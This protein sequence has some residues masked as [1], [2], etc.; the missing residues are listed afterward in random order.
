LRPAPVQVNFFCPGTSGTDYLD[1]IISDRVV[2]PEDHHVHYS[3][4]VVYLPDTFQ[5][6]DSRR[7]IAERT[8]SRAEAGLPDDGFVFCSFNQPYKFTPAMF[9]VWMRLLHR[10]EGSVL[11]LPQ[12]N[13]TAAR[14]LRRE[15]AHR[16]IDAGRLIFAPRVPKPEDH[17]ARYRLADLFLDTLPYNAQTTASD[18]LWAGVPVITCLGTTFVGRVAATLLNAIGLPELITH[19]L[20]EY[21]ALA[22]KLAME[23]QVLADIKAKLARNRGT[24]PLF[25]TDRFRR[26]LE[27]AYT[28]MWERHQRGEPPAS[29][30]VPEIRRDGAAA[31]LM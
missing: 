15:A 12:V 25:D 30:A 11:W 21:E 6:N 3:E 20:P 31:G 19:S 27:A 23:R 26:H 17:L 10:V 29:F 1:Y 9:D 14:N 5:A 8:P 22:L 7:R 28:A 4:K 18:A 2:I 24:H 13:A 16:G